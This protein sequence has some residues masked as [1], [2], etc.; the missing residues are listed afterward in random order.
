M[1]ESKRHSVLDFI[2]GM[3]I[4]GSLAAATT[5]LFGTEKGKKIQK[6][7]LNKVD[8]FRKDVK[9]SVNKSAR[10]KVKQKVKKA[11]KTQVR[12][13]RKELAKKIAGNPPKTRRRRKTTT[14]GKK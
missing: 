9:K 5:F 6:N 2:E 3:I 11:V 10:Q 8:K 7:L 1:F 13:G 14:R 4:G 12:K